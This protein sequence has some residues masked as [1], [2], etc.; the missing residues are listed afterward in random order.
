MGSFLTAFLDLSLPVSEGESQTSLARAEQERLAHLLAIATHAQTI[1][2]RLGGEASPDE[3]ADDKRRGKRVE[4]V[5][6]QLLTAWGG[7]PSN[8]AHDVNREAAQVNWQRWWQ[9]HE[10]WLLNR[11]RYLATWCHKCDGDEKWTKSA[12]TRLQNEIKWISYALR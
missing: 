3:L 10:T 6:G 5:A 9:E 7:R 8:Y 4:H 2:R 11:Q 1:P 12:I